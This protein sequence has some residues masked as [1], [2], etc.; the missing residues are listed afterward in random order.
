MSTICKTESGNTGRTYHVIEGSSSLIKDVMSE[1]NVGIG[2][3]TMRRMF[4]ECRV[5]RVCRMGLGESELR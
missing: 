1:T 2:L 5:V 4:A 3:F